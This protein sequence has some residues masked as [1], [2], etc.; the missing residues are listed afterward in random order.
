MGRASASR[1]AELLHDRIRTRGHVQHA[2]KAQI[3]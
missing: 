3:P 2:V 1:L